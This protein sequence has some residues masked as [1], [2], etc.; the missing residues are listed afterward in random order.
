MGVE[1]DSLKMQ[2]QNVL[3]FTMG[4]LLS[5]YRMDVG[6]QA[7]SSCSA[8]FAHFHFFCFGGEIHY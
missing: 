7:W 1:T 4:D 5:K 2:L 6:D 8:D 3:E